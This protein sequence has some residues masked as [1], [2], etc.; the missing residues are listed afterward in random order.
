MAIERT[1]VGVRKQAG[2]LEHHLS[3]VGDVVHRRLVTTRGQPTGRFVV[4]QFR[5]FAQREERLGAAG[6]STRL[7]HG[8]H[9]VEAHV[10]S[11]HVRR[12]LGEGAVPAAVATEFRQRNED[13]GRIGDDVTVS[14]SGLGERGARE[15]VEWGGEEFRVCS[16][17]SQRR[18]GDILGRDLQ[19]LN[20][21]LKDEPR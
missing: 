4:A 11:G 14:G 21:F 9:F 5:S 15:F 10:R 7:G 13:L 19:R 3:G 18:H 12:R 6:V 20:R 16:G 8:H 2:A 1:G 17:P